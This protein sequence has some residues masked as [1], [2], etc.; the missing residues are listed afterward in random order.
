M[1]FASLALRVGRV[2]RKPPGYVA[3]RLLEAAAAQT[4]SVR[5]PLRANRMTAKRLS[6]LFDCA[7]THELSSRLAANPFPFLSD[8][9]RARTF[10]DQYPEAAEKVLARAEDALA[11]RVDLLGSG[12]VSLG[13]D[14]RWS[15]DYK[16]NTEWPIRFC[17]WIE[18][19]NLDRPSDVKFPWELSRMQWMIPL[20]Q[21]YLMTG[22]ERYADEAATL[23]LSWIDRNP[24]ARSINWAC[25]M[26]VAL[27]A[28]SWVWFFHAFRSS[29]AWQRAEFLDRFLP[30]LFLHGDFISRH[31]ERADVNGNHFTANAAGLVFCGLF[32]GEVGDA[33]GWCAEGREILE[34]EIVC[35]VYE[36]GVNYESS[37]PYHRLVQELFLYPAVY[38]ESA[39]EAVGS[40]YRDRLR[41]MAR[42]T[43]AYSRPDGSVPLWG[44]ADDART[45]PFGTQGIND[46]RYLVRLAGC[47]LGDAAL[48][49]SVA[50]DF[51]EEFWFFHGRSES[52]R[53]S[54][55]DIET[56][57]VRFSEGGFFVMRNAT[58]HVFIDC[59]PLGLAGRGGHGHND[60]L[61][62]EAVLCGERLVSD[63]GAYLYSASYEQ[64]N[65]F[66]STAYHNTPQIDGEEINRFV[67]PEALWVLHND[68]RHC[69][70]TWS[71]GPEIDE[72]AGGHDGYARLSEPVEVRRR[73]TL[74][75][76]AHELCIEDRF[77]GRG[78]HV[79]SIPLHL[80][81]GVEVVRRGC[82]VVLSAGTKRFQVRWES[83]RE[84]QLDIGDGR[85]SESYGRVT[86]VERLCWVRCGSL[87]S[88]RVSIAPLV[89][90]TGGVGS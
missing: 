1:S 6:R 14:V 10:R 13:S 75:H 72:F 80:A 66:R 53:S 2:L 61:S 30:A 9:A 32:F 86:A 15:M 51:D 25:T 62:F 40:E 23:V 28:I 39:S 49:C 22:D 11:H 37:I 77:E 59:G 38:L 55:E 78:E 60:L 63:C 17:R 69:V 42:F 18:Y 8:A 27:R 82:D 5:A 31:L 89:D 34:T 48:E 36:D 21:A 81:P 33:R 24:Y 65:L 47:F 26:D 35:Q 16:T 12:V 20:G 74:N 54:T 19:N 44:D 43:A 88:L 90:M 56:A 85:V 70:E 67:A 58:D 3:R 83:E 76:Q 46:H 50:G 4:E 87:A 41:N 68:A 73:M 84:W 29:S 71:Q 79:V 52:E 64:R 7:D 45:M 57:S